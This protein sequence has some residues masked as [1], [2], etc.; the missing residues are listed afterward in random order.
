MGKILLL[1]GMTLTFAVVVCA[2]VIAWFDNPDDDI[3]DRDIPRAE[4]QR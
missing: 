3:L 4:D 2:S 1:V